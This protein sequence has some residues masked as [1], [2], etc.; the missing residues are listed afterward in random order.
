M[1]SYKM[2]GSACFY[3]AEDV[4]GMPV[5]SPDKYVKTI[6]FGVTDKEIAEKLQE[7]LAD[8]YGA[9]K[10]LM[11]EKPVGKSGS[12]VASDIKNAAA[13]EISIADLGSIE[14]YDKEDFYVIL[15]DSL[16]ER[17]RFSFADLAEI[18]DKLRAP[19]GC[20]WDKEQTHESIRVNL[21][22]EAYELAEAIDLKD[23]A[24][25]REEA[26][27][28]LL[29]SVFHAAIAK[30]RGAFNYTDML[31]ELCTKLLTRHT[32]IFGDNHA[33]NAEQALGFWEKAKQEEK[34]YST[35]S[36]KIDGIA[37]NLPQLIYAYKLQK[38]AKK[39]GFDWEDISGC[40]DKLDEEIEELKNAEGDNIE[41]EAGDVLFATVNVLRFLNVEPERA[42]ELANRKFT[43]RFKHME[44][45]LL[46]EGKKLNES[47]LE[48]MEEK[49]QESKRFYP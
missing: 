15:P 24:K 3:R 19:D 5:F 20:E 6:L 43:L 42:L 22:E 45:E 37:K 18:M 29:Q 49:W 32:H 10:K 21:I 28:V 34:K 31:T 16:T 35:Y 12:G 13:V 23:D 41:K 8:A 39:S 4:L 27:D 11:I 17:M 26:G 44:T 46:K 30:D 36:D 47:T 25:M 9:E 2:S 1:K 38:A 48:E 14:S 7:R 33:D 40:Y